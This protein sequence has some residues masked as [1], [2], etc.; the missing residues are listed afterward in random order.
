M[1]NIRDY[2]MVRSVDFRATLG[3]AAST[4]IDLMRK[5][6]TNPDPESKGTSKPVSP[7]DIRNI[8]ESRGF[9][10][11]SPAQ[12]ISFMICK[13]GVGKTTS[14][15]FTA[16][17]MSAYGAKVL[18][19]DAD[20]QGN[21]TSAFAL[22]TYGEQIDEGTPVLNDVVKGEVS[23]DQAIL[24]ITP[25]LHLLPSTPMN[26]LLEGQIRDS[27]R[28]AG[29]ILPALF[30]PLL[31]RY[32]YIMFDCAPALNLTNTAIVSISN[33]VVLPVSPD[34][35]S[36]LGLQ[37]TLA[38]IA[39][40]EQDFGLNLDKRILFT[41]YDGREL[42]SL[43]YLSGIMQ[44]YKDLTFKS[45]IRTSAD[46]KNAITRKEDLF[47]Y[48]KSNAKEDYDKFVQELMGLESIKKV[49]RSSPTL[50]A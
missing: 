32:D 10:Y 2:F 20:P 23:I 3:I 15:F 36:Q 12:V 39:Q 16:Q 33:R 6:G 25:N 35:F 14:T 47:G 30:A 46:V 28:P 48:K 37:Q 38:D 1:Q 50:E 7:V 42:T 19:V 13:G 21:L 34:K 22:E 40:I 17:R 26:A 24:A 18:L 45:M 31:S 5:H 44:N 4:Y 9:R 11:P 8:F 29:K 27:R 49:P 41:K 43:M